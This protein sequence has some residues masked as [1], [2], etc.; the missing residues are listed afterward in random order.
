MAALCCA[1]ALIAGACA[2]TAPENALAGTQWRVATL[3]ANTYTEQGPTIEFAGDRVVGSGG[4]N[5]FFGGYRT[6]G[7]AVS[8]SEIGSTEMACEPQIMQSETAFF[9]ALAASR[10]FRRLGDTLILGDANGGTIVLR[11]A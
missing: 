7:E 8:F 11:P 10:T 4:C 3:G 5:R 9:Q 2:S 1:G 6:E